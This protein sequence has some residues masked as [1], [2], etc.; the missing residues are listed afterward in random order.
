MLH[1]TMRLREVHDI[2][3]A[4]L[5]QLAKLSAAPAKLSDGSDGFSVMGRAGVRAG[6]RRI[7]TLPLGP[8]VATDVARLL[9]HT[10]VREEGD[11]SLA[12]P[13]SYQP[14]LTSVQQLRGQ[15]STVAAILKNSITPQR[16]GQF[17]VRLPPMER[18][19]GIDG[20][21]DDMA[22]ISEAID[23]PMV[24]LLGAKVNVIGFDRGSAWLEI[25]AHGD[26]AAELLIAM[27]T[28][29]KIIVETR[30]KHRL[31]IEALK[32][33]KVSTRI[34]EMQEEVF[35]AQQDNEAQEQAEH[36]IVTVVPEKHDAD[37][38]NVL[39]LVRALRAGANF[40]QDGGAL[41]LPQLPSAT[42]A[43]GPIER[44]LV[45][46]SPETLQIGPAVAPETP[47]PEP[48]TGPEKDA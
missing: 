10:L 31:D 5:A 42:T 44:P 11:E 47:T 38:S 37:R 45:E 41:E 35:R 39:A 34:V 24:R 27:V 25:L 7:A 6:L 32:R 3:T 19:D 12:R 48:T 33:S 1:A 9:E 8:A 30:T 21:R 36:I 13:G 22:R 2:L 29:W 4:A 28:A 26:K 46:A 14:L 15:L 17:A 16:E 43:N 20:V 23:A 18:R 40:L